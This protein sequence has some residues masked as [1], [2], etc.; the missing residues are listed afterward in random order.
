MSIQNESKS[1]SFNIKEFLLQILSYKYLYAASF[2]I[3]ISIAFLINKLSPVVYEVNSIIG[4]VEDKRSS[5]LESNNLFSGLGAFPQ[6]RN[7]ENDINSLSSFSLVSAT[8]RNLN[9]EIGYFR[10]KS[11]LFGQTQQMY[12]NS[13]FMVN[14]DKSH[15]QPINARFY[16]Q[17]LDEHSYRLTSSEDEV[18]L[19]NYVDNLIISRFNTL[20][21]DTICKFNETITNNKF[22]FLISLN[23]E[24]L[25]DILNDPDHFFFEF[26]HLDQLA[27]QYLGRLTVEPVSIKSSQIKCPVSG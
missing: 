15:V 21:I 4:P 23:K 27:K 3:C 14:L 8:V 5:L 25:T 1:E 16:I 9:L 12:N 10:E 6:Q 13:P 18:S 20:R 22:K 17:I 19:Y 7:L 24:L 2:M 26:Y 11:R